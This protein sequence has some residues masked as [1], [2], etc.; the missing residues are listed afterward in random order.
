MNNLILII[1]T[2]NGSLPPIECDSVH[3]T[4]CD[5]AKGKNGGSYGIRKG[6][7]NAIFSLES[8]KTT[9]LLN[10]ETVFSANTS[11]GFATV[12]QDTVTVVIE[13]Y[14]NNI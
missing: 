3:L 7:V 9:A 4:V 8:G 12:N 6:H 10:G 14:E 2:P 1:A 11:N 5:D 13:N